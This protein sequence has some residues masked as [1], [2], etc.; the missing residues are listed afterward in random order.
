MT[1]SPAD[2]LSRRTPAPPEELASAI[3]AALKTKPDAEK[4]PSPTELLEAAQALLEKVLKDDCARRES[5]LDLL[6][7]DALVTYALEIATEK[8]AS[9]RDFPEYAMDRLA[10]KDK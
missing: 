8:A 9:L 10:G 1:D 7:A 2:W 3:R 4:D 5:A 6:T